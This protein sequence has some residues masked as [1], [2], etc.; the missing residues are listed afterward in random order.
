MGPFLRFASLRHWRSKITP[1]VYLFFLLVLSCSAG[2]ELTRQDS[3]AVSQE[4]ESTAFLHVKITVRDIDSRPVP[5]LSKKDFHATFA[6]QP[7][8][9]QDAHALTTGVSNNPTSLL[10]MLPPMTPGARNQMLTEA[11]KHLNDAA[12]GHWSVAV[13][14]PSGNFLPFTTETSRMESSIH[15]ILSRIDTPQYGTHWQQAAH[16]AMRELAGLPGR[17]VVVFCTDPLF[18]DKKHFEL[19]P[20]LTR[21]GPL[22]VEDDATRG[23]TQVYPLE[24]S[25]PVLGIPFGDASAEPLA[26][27][28]DI[29][30]TSVAVLGQAQLDMERG[31]SEAQ[32]AAWAVTGEI[33]NST[34][35]R[36]E[37]SLTHAFRD[38][39]RD[40]EGTYDL[41]LAVD[42]SYLDGGYYSLSIS[43]VLP[44]MKVF[45]P[46]WLNTPFAF[47]E[48]K[49]LSIDPLLG[50]LLEGTSHVQG[51]PLHL[52][53]WYFPDL[54]G[55][56]ASIVL[57]AELEGNAPQATANPPIEFAGQ[58]SSLTD[59]TNMVLWQEDLATSSAKNTVGI[60]SVRTVQLPPG[61]YV[62]R[63]AAHDSQ[64][65]EAGNAS[66]RFKV[67][68]PD[69][70]A[71][72][73]ISSLLLSTQC[74][75]GIQLKMG[76]KN[77]L[78]PLQ[79]GDCTLTPLITP[80]LHRNDEM[81]VLLRLYRS[82]APIGSFPKDWRASIHIWDTSGR[83][84][85]QRPTQINTSRI[86]GWEISAD[87]SP[88]KEHLDNGAYEIG[89]VVYG[90]KKRQFAVKDH[91]SISN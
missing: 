62:Y 55:S 16:L 56:V 66:F 27:I 12:S 65:Q 2:S 11:M 85:Y 77:L 20:N 86:R 64:T 28:G 30:S 90:P 57:A 8:A 46:K 24:T 14:D 51:L 36:T 19:N 45:F 9:V 70:N 7:V 80:V 63:A 21:V 33:T 29:G 79:N 37:N 71:F 4:S 3:A 5:G 61:D 35:G 31:A 34:G 60:S 68:A 48:Q 88:A 23:M 18:S 17:H 10:L 73:G 32:G 25:R 59:A 69:P 50:H 84:L 91:F 58:I 40:A 76:R 26:N 54:P 22:L 72:L 15:S 38:I 41:T 75:P 78:N 81:H 82:S 67:N 53:A 42:R 47:P 13:L 43:T 44:H 89:V 87:I 52:R 74:L 83:L 39:A 1:L 49:Q 6:G